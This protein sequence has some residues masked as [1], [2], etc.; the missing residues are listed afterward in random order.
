MLSCKVKFTMLIKKK[1]RTFFCNVCS[2]KCFMLICW[3]VGVECSFSMSK[4]LQQK[5]K[6]NLISP[7]LPKY[8]FNYFLKL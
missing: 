8:S 1:N 7:V 3:S 2:I 4:K 6:S 5:K